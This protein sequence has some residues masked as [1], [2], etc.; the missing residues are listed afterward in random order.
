MG[1]RQIESDRDDVRL[2]DRATAGDRAAFHQL[3]TAYAPLV[4]RIAYRMLG[5]ADDAADLTQDIFVR[6][7]QRLGSLR[8]GQAFQAWL[9]RLAMN[10]AHDALRR[11]RPPFF[12]LDAAPPGLPE[13]AE[14]QL[15][16]PHPGSADVILSAELTARVQQALLALSPD[17]R[18]VVVLHHLEAMPVEEIAD[19]L[20]IPIGTVKS[21]LSRARA[22]LRRRLEEYVEA[23]AG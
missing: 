9:T 10:M 14:W 5:H 17:H 13:E 11:R 20:H 19:V 8:D 6:A 3:Y 2:V 1:Q 21:R 15:A 18:A 7:F 4:Y 16:D 22:E 12:S 23:D